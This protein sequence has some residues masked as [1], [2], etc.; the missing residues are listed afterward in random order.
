M[1]FTEGLLP[2]CGIA[3]STENGQMQEVF[4][5]PCLCPLWLF[6]LTCT[7]RML[8]LPFRFSYSFF[9]FK[10]GSG[11]PRDLT[12]PV[13]LRRVPDVSACSPFHLLRS[14]NLLWSGN[15]HTFHKQNQEPDTPAPRLQGSL[16]ACGCKLPQGGRRADYFHTLR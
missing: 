7:P 1:S 15:F 12:L 11:W 14:R 5:S 10:R 2:G 8:S 3:L 4:G 16:L 13:D 9:F 6:G